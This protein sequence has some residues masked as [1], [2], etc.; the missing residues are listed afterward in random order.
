MSTCV[1]VWRGKAERVNVMCL[2]VEQSCE[3]IPPYR[4]KYASE[5]GVAIG[6]DSTSVSWLSNSTPTVQSWD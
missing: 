2:H 5:R 3:L 1:F 6:R 4:S